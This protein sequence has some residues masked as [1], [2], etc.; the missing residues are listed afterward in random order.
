M[1]YT[2]KSPAIPDTMNPRVM[3]RDDML[4]TAVLHAKPFFKMHKFAVLLI[5]LNLS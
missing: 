5:I 1:T 4:K 3:E 2:K